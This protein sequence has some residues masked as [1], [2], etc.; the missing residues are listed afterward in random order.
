MIIYYQ[1]VEQRNR[2]SVCLRA[3]TETESTHIFTTRPGCLIAFLEYRTTSLPSV[4]EQH[5][6]FAILAASRNAHTAGRR[7]DPIRPN[8]VE[9]IM[10][11]I[12]FCQHTAYQI[13]LVQQYLQNR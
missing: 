9:D 10:G 5:G 8:M 4:V 7:Q 6:H 3:C 2:E 12:K 1:E 13:N 11:F